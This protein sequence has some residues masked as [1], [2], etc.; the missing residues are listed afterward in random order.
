MKTKI[1][2]LCCIIIVSCFLIQPGYAQKKA[3]KKP[4]GAKISKVA[5]NAAKPASIQD[6]DLLEPWNG[7]AGWSDAIFTIDDTGLRVDDG[8]VGPIN[9]NFDFTFYGTIK[10]QCYISSNGYITFGSSYTGYSADGLPLT[11]ADASVKMIAGYFG[12]VDLRNL[13]SGTV[14][15]KA[16]AHRFVV[17]YDHVGYY[18][19]GGD[20]LNTFEIII[21]DGTDP[22]IGVGKNVGFSYGDM[23][24]TEGDNNTVGVNAGDGQFYYQLGVFSAEGSSN[25]TGPMSTDS[26][27]D[28]LDNKNSQCSGLTDGFNIDISKPFAVAWSRVPESSNHLYS[29]RTYA[30]E[31]RALGNFNAKVEFSADGGASWSTVASNLPSTDLGY[32]WTVPQVNSTNCLIKISKMDDAAIY[33]VSPVFAIVYLEQILE[34]NGGENY[35]A[36][37]NQT[38]KWYDHTDLLTSPSQPPSN[39]NNYQT[40]STGSGAAP[41]DLNDVV[42]LLYTIDGG[43]TWTTIATNVKS[44]S[45]AEN[46]YSWTTPA[47]ASTLCKIKIRQSIVFKTNPAS[48]N[49]A[50]FYSV[51]DNYFTLYQSAANGK[52]VLTTPNGGE[53]YV[54]GSYQYINWRKTGG[55]VYG[56]VQVEYSIDGGGTWVKLNKTPIA[57]LTRYSWQTPKVNSTNCLV[58]LSN[59]ISHQIFDVSERAF[60]ITTATSVRNYPNPFNPTTKIVF[61]LENKAYVSLKIFNSIG[62]QVAELVNKQLESG[63]YE[64]EFNG[65]NLTS[66][67][68]FY[69]LSVDGQSQVNKMILMK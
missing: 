58:R 31:W 32:L 18:N 29:N 63:E 48:P 27:I 12:D 6:C 10:T 35:L 16:G 4:G 60:T 20:K 2:Q 7:G 65:A 51:S 41:K 47:T 1:L 42:D 34:P 59:Y 9:L 36:G 40:S 45:G 21:T 54:G 30:L 38:I 53:K 19:N 56:A 66:G 67:V 61:G 69:N 44:L 52:I 43:T 22:I 46:T 15:Y 62:Q 5:A 57:G 64:Y 11:G 23:Q 50:G 24:W 39:G 33:D 28:W 55:I 14:H 49:A 17:L 8:A 25:Y 68:Y 13:S 26:G 3:G 37:S